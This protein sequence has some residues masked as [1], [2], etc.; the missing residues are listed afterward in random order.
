MFN[1]EEQISEWRRQMLAAGIPT[2]VPLEELEIHLRENIEGQVSTGMNVREAFEN[3]VGHIGQAVALN[4]EFV[5]AG[6][7]IQERVKKM[8]Y[9]LA[10]I[11]NLQ[12]V[13]NMNTPNPNSEPRWA[14]YAKAGAFIF[15]AAFMWLFTVV[16]VLPK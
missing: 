9:A 16:F 6:E 12:P 2:P 14:T 15:P 11:P 13:T 5:K 4:N 10:G 3:S 1:L 7:T 8:I